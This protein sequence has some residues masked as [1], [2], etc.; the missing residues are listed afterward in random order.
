[1]TQGF[2][3]LDEAANA[4]GMAPDELN[5]MAQRREVRAFADRGTW[6]FRTQDID[7]MVQ[8][9]G[10]APAAVADDSAPAGEMSPSGTG[11]T[12]M[13]PSDSGFGITG[14]GPSDSGLE[15]PSGN[16]GLDA[17]DESGSG[18]AGMT[19]SG[20]GNTGMTPSS[21]GS[22]GMTPSG[23]GTGVTA[24]DGMEDISFED[25]SLEDLP[26]DEAPKTQLSPRKGETTVAGAAL[27]DDLIPL[28][29]GLAEGP[30]E[31][32][33][34]LGDL[35]AMDL[36]D[37]KPTPPPGTGSGRLALEQASFDF[38]G[39]SAGPPSG[40][41]KPPS[42]GRL[43]KS[44]QSGSNLGSGVDLG[45]LSGARLGGS[46]AKMKGP[47]SGKMKGPSS[48][49]MT[50]SGGDSDVR[51][52]FDGST[53]DDSLISGSLK[54]DSDVRLDPMGISKPPSGTGGGAMD[55][56]ATEE[57]DL[58]AELHQAD[59]AS[60][61]RLKPR[62]QQSKTKAV[63]GKTQPPGG[64]KGTVLPTSSPF[65]LSEDDLELSSSS[66][67]GEAHKPLGSEFELTL[68]PEDEPS[69]LA[70]GDD[71]DVDLG[72]LKPSNELSSS[73]RAELSGIN[74]HDPADSGISLEKGDGSDSVDFE[75][76]VDDD[77]TGPKTI[78]GKIPDSDS[79]F[80][81]TLEDS[82]GELSASMEG[83]SDSGEQK[84]IFET[85]F[86]LPALEESGSQAVAL[87]EADTDLESSD[88]DLALEE[89]ES[90]SGSVP[91]IDESGSQVV[92]LD[93]EEE[94]AAAAAPKKR[95]FSAIHGE[96]SE[97]ELV[98][99]EDEAAD[100]ER[101]AEGDDGEPATIPAAQAEWGWY[102][103]L[104]LAP[105]VAVMFIAGLMS[106]ELLHGMW[107][108]HT[109]SKPSGLVVRGIAT[110]FT[111]ELPKE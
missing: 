64:D 74:L 100:I 1:M 23:S 5:R 16:D 52:D 107:G 68:A 58:D 12:G 91:E 27:D 86:D 65:E 11:N 48:G 88:F 94:A 57:I 13:G 40:T 24:G 67:S 96:G 4:L 66:S 109:S 81:L 46:S 53:A 35:P 69:P 108:Y 77:A 26:M 37:T 73:A 20:T 7:E 34:S 110:L 98:L 85:D 95:G 41:L 38:E 97:G 59:L 33:V 72:D 31:S 90:G 106:Y 14:M 17:F 84:D 21:T 111:E 25:V 87:D 43:A 63:P 92:A 47:N 15:A 45:S 54:P 28:D 55:V 9:Q 32:T 30:S 83:S 29:P 76:T 75:L 44:G 104:V 80:E 10:G 62:S 101:E 8:K 18:D 42:S 36:P 89:G 61:Q 102:P 2:Y 70:L 71:E 93:E 50:G 3:T 51:L 39:G 56:G 79:E 99:D 60:Q 6:R 49:R 22:T 105:C 19:P 82:A 103:V 78:K